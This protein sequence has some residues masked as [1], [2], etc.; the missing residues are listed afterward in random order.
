MSNVRQDYD[1][2]YMENHGHAP[3]DSEI[4]ALL[5]SIGATYVVESG[6]VTVTCRNG[7][8]W[9]F[10]EPKRMTCNASTR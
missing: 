4:F 7:E 10:T 9:D 3:I 2:A 8:M 1:R 6:I 5:D